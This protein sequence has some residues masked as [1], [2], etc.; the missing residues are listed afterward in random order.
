MTEKRTKKKRSI[1]DGDNGRDIRRIVEA[2][3]IMTIII[4]VLLTGATSTDHG[5]RAIVIGWTSLNKSKCKRIGWLD[6]ATICRGLELNG[7]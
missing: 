2:I 3:A 5:S 6:L 7:L 1:D 4:M